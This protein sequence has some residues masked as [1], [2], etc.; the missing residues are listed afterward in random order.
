MEKELEIEPHKISIEEIEECVLEPR[1]MSVDEIQEW[2]LRLTDPINEIQESL[3]H[4]FEFGLDEKNQL[5]K[6]Q[7]T[8]MEKYEKL[9]E[10]TRALLEKLQPL[11]TPSISEVSEDLE[12]RIEVADSSEDI[13]VNLDAEPPGPMTF[14]GEQKRAYEKLRQ[15]MLEARDKLMKDLEN[16]QDK[17]LKVSNEH[18]RLCA[19]VG[20]Q[21]SAPVYE[22]T[23]SVKAQVPKKEILIPCDC[24]DKRD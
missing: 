8:L 11:S 5:L 12:W 4:S 22:C 7:E 10:L 6:I 3:L 13:S 9:D 16:A 23:V 15:E 21:N 17:L 2:A 20:E 19:D 18:K 1:E 24:L 14:T